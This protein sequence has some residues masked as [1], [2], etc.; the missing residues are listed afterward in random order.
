MIAD[1]RTSPTWR[2]CAHS[3]VEGRCTSCGARVCDQQPYTGGSDGTIG[4]GGVPVGHMLPDAAPRV[5]VTRL[6]R[7]T[8]ERSPCR[9]GHTG[10]WFVNA[11][12]VPECRECERLLQRA[13]RLRS[14]VA[15]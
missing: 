6:R 1:A 15:A 10:P 11:R 8:I 13:R 4:R 9:R 5:V 7:D 12:G 14:R 2:R 3:T